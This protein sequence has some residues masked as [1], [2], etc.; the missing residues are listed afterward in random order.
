MFKPFHEAISYTKFS[1]A[2]AD[3]LNNLSHF[4]RFDLNDFAYYRLIK[5]KSSKT[6]LKKCKY[7]YYFESPSII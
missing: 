2:I 3:I 7:A 4:T 5:D 6:I 1:P